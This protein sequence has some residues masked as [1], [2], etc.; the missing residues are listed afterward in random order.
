MLITLCSSKASFSCL[1]VKYTDRQTDK[2]ANKQAD[3]QT[4]SEC[5]CLSCYCGSQA[6]FSCLTVK[7]TDRLEG[8]QTG[9]QTDRHT[10]LRKTYGEAVLL[11][12][13]MQFPR[14]PELSAQL[15]ILLHGPTQQPRVHLRLAT[16]T[17]PNSYS[18]NTTESP[19]QTGNNNTPQLL[20]N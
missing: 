15:G 12:L 17:H 9:R 19:S 6:S 13:L 20:C 2:H 4:Y 1:T 11:I 5:V 14:Q 3:R 18:I 16:T 7:H 10:V 8:R